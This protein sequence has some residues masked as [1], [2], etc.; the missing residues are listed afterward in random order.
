M[1]R[2]LRNGA[3]F[4]LAVH[5]ALLFPGW[6][7][8]PVSVDVERGPVSFE[9]ELF[10]EA[11]VIVPEAARHVPEPTAEPQ[12]E[13]WLQD[14]ANSSVRPRSSPASSTGHGAFVYAQ[15]QGTVNRP[16]AY[17]WLAWIRGW[18]GLVILQV[19]VES[20]GQ[21]R[22]VEVA[23]SSGY[24]I[25]DAAAQRAIQQWEF[26]PAKRDGRAVR[27]ELELPIRFQLTSSKDDRP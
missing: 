16:P 20:N 25:L 15:P 9:V 10:S 22:Q 2:D 6:I 27:S 14:H 1:R 7:V 26:T 24:P 23:R 18:E 21:P 17:P 4:S 8:R 3:L 5:G 19:S 13:S 11:Q 12:G